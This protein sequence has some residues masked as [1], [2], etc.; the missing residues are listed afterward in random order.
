MT[1]RF[2]NSTTPLVAAAEEGEFGDVIVMDLPDTDDDGNEVTPP[3]DP[4]PD[5]VEEQVNAL[6]LPLVAR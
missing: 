4:W 6:F 5:G 1:V 2:G 3:P